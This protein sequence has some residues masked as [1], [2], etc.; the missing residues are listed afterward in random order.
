[1]GL[2]TLTR[3]TSCSKYLT[4]A[5]QVCPSIPSGKSFGTPWRIG[6]SKVSAYAFPIWFA[7]VLSSRRPAFIPQSVLY[8]PC[9]EAHNRIRAHLAD[10][11]LQRQ[12]KL[13]VF[14]LKIV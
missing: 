2:S 12:Q 10:V 8:R 1:M 7:M 6:H 4:Q 9:R 5:A 13:V 14:L 3:M 11:M